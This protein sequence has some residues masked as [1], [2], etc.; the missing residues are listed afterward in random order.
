[1]ISS[2]LHEI[3]IAP[4][5]RLFGSDPEVPVSNNFQPPS[6]R[7][8]SG[9]QHSSSSGIF[10]KTSLV[11]K[12]F[13]GQKQSLLRIIHSLVIFDAL[14]FQYSSY[15]RPL[16]DVI[17]K[18]GA[19]NRPLRSLIDHLPMLRQLHRSKKYLIHLRT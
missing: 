19:K 4:E 7:V 14:N 13:Y 17:A 5:A 12:A 8:L 3:E 11:A 15:R 10:L 6:P 2:N 9:R 18:T 1:M 16:R